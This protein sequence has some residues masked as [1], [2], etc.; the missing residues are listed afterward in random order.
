[1]QR[2]S[3][4]RAHLPTGDRYEAGLS[5][6]ATRSMQRRRFFMIPAAGSRVPLGIT[7]V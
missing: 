1:M 7:G 3:S 2:L 6:A 4:G 5:P